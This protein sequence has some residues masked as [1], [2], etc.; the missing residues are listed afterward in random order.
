MDPELIKKKL[1]YEERKARAKALQLRLTCTICGAKPRTLLN[2][3][4]GTTQYCSTDCQRIDWRD[5]GHRKACKKIR[6]E[7]AAE[8]ARAEAPAPPPRD[9]VYGPAPRSRA[10]EIRARIAAEHE[11]ARARREANPEPEPVSA[12][13]GSRCPICLEEWDV[14][15]NQRFRVCCCRTVCQSC[16]D[17]I[18]SD[19]CPL[20]RAPCA[21]DNET[22]LAHIRRHVENHSPEAIEKLGNCYEFGQLGLVK[23]A[24]KAAK[25]YK[26][27]VELGEARAMLHLS[28][29][30]EI[31]DGVKQD[32]AKSLQLLRMAAE[33]GDATAQHNLASRLKAGEQIRGSLAEHESFRWYKLAAEQG[34]TAAEVKVGLAYAS[35]QGVLSDFDEC[36]RWMARAAAKGDEFA[37]QLLGLKSRSNEPSEKSANVLFNDSCM[38]YDQGKFEESARFCKLA[39]EKGF[40]S[41]QY[42]LANFFMKGEGVKRDEEECKRWLERAAAQ[43]HKNA[44]TCLAC[45]AAGIR[46]PP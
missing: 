44:E 26:R 36:K 5:R 46:P 38:L 42:N 12:R 11:A 23:S 31:G 3:P 8:A 17:K 15:A 1:E 30:Y 20:C 16:E 40:A 6:D 19:A 33:R 43:G 45:L 34:L 27:A 29:L 37:I 32:K 35:G 2:C 14:N 9:V 22:K 13:Y 21:L 39:A 41:A 4:C 10:D 7:R 25:L 28:H 24:K 18:G